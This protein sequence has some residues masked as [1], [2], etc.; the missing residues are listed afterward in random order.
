MSIKIKLKPFLFP[1]VLLLVAVLTAFKLHGSSNGM[2]NL[3]FYGGGY[4]DPDLLYG[5]T[6]AIRPKK[7]QERT[8]AKFLQTGD[9]YYNPNLT[10]ERENFDLNLP[11]F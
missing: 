1:L 3:Y 11:R 2:Y 9:P 8:W 5:R 10:L 6:R 7:V 4:R